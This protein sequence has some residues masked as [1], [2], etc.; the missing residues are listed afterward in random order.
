MNDVWEWALRPTNVSMASSYDGDYTAVVPVEDV[1]LEGWS[2]VAVLDTG[3]IIR[4]SSW[5]RGNWATY[6]MPLIV[7]WTADADFDDPRPWMYGLRSPDGQVF[8]TLGPGFHLPDYGPF[9][10]DEQS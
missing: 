8:P 4:Q 10:P 1:D 3:E 9:Y 5:E 7:A 2:L 6:T